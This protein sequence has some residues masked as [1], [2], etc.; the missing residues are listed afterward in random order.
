MNPRRHLPWLL[1]AL[2]FGAVV[3]PLLV[4]FT[5]S[6]TLGPYSRGGPGRFLLDFLVDLGRLRAAAWALLAGPAI[7]VL[8]WRILVAYAWRGDTD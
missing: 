8:V 4:Y 3:L 6:V 5:G 2:A 1:A 7:L